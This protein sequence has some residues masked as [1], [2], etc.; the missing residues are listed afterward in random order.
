MSEHLTA[1]YFWG[2]GTGERY[3]L[4]AEGVVGQNGRGEEKRGGGMNQIKTVFTEYVVTNPLK[5]SGG[6]QQHSGSAMWFR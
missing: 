6:K 2:C 3:V 4:V 5:E 1:T